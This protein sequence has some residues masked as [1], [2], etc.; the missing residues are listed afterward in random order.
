MSLSTRVGFKTTEVLGLVNLFLRRYV[1]SYRMLDYWV[2]GGFEPE[3]LAA[4]GSGSLR[5]W[6]ANDVRIVLAIA[7][8]REL[9]SSGGT[10]NAL[11]VDRILVIADLLRAHHG[12]GGVLLRASGVDWVDSPPDTLVSRGPFAYMPVL[13]LADVEVIVE[14][15]AP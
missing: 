10:T 11:T 4:D 9:L 5:R 1:V 7:P 13:S 3:I 2:R 15:D 14:W 6:S 12:A 8:F